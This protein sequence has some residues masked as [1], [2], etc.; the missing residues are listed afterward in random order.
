[1]KTS[2][3]PEPEE[4]PVPGEP[5]GLALSFEEP[6]PQPAQARI[7]TRSRLAGYLG[8][9]LVSTTDSPKLGCRNA[10]DGLL[11]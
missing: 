6:S 9:F 4:L 10:I 8:A 7:E 5:D 11:S 2:R 3:G 1:M